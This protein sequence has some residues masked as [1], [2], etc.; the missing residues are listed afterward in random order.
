MAKVLK[1]DIK[2]LTE[3]EMNQLTSTYFQNKKFINT[4]YVVNRTKI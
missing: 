1:P 2:W 3:M 4:V